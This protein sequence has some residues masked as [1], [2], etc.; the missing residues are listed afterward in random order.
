MAGTL[1]YS[2]YFPLFGDPNIKIEMVVGK[3]FEL[4]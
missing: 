1:F 2:K 4:P 3:A